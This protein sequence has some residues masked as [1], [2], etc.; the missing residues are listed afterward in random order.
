MALR[1][2]HVDNL[3]DKN[4]SK[5]KSVMAA[6]A[7]AAMFAVDTAVPTSFGM[8]H[9]ERPGSPAEKDGYGRRKK[10]KKITAHRGGSFRRV[11]SMTRAEFYEAVKST[12]SDKPDP[13]DTKYW[14]RYAR[15]AA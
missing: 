3:E 11:K 13:R 1:R 8:R 7:F 10:P 12:H 6:A 14:N 5:I 15:R 4:M 2:P 9:T